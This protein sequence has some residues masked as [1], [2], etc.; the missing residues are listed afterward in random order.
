MSPLH[1]FL[2]FID[3]EKS[4]SGR[5]KSPIPILSATIPAG[6]RRARRHRDE[7]TGLIWVARPTPLD[8]RA[9]IGKMTG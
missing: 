9:D 4:I 1:G 3:A 7:D 5:K 6:Y 2:P 8:C